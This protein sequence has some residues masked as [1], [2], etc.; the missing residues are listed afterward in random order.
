VIAEK[1]E[2]VIDCEGCGARIIVVQKDHGGWESEHQCP[3]LVPPA[4]LSVGEEVVWL[5]TQGG[6]GGSGHRVNEKRPRRAIVRKIGPRAVQIRVL[7]R[8]EDW[9][10]TWVRRENIRAIAR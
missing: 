8:P 10:V 5:S 3:D 7:G 6:G 9:G 4:N 1:R 2:A